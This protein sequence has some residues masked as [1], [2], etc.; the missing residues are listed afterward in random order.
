M[1]SI[2]GFYRKNK[3][4]NFSINALPAVLI[5]NRLFPNLCF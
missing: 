2:Y 4:Y 3:F 1:S 5:V